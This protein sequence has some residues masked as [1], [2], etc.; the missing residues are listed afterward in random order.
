MCKKN[1]KCFLFI[2]TDLHNLACIMQIRNEIL[3]LLTEIYE[4]NKRRNI[5]DLSLLIIQNYNF[6]SLKKMSK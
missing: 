3:L 6:N 2:L 4:H 5:S 1:V